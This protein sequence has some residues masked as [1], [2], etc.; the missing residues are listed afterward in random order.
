MDK[1]TFDELAAQ[2]KL[3]PGA[4]RMAKEVLCNGL[5]ATQAAAQEN[6]L[7]QSADKKAK[8]ATRQLANQAANRILKE[9]R[10]VDKYPEEW[11]TVTTTLPKTWAQLVRYIQTIEYAK[12]NLIVKSAPTMPAFELAEIAEISKMV[13]VI[14]Q[15]WRKM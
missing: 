6:A 10:R 12:A 13:E 8:I 9:M 1:Q 14:L 11:V 5:S 7:Q 2:T 4:L 3:K 15:K